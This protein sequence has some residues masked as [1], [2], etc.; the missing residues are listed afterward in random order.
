MRRLRTSTFSSS[1]GNRIAVRAWVLG[2]F[3]RA[4]QPDGVALAQ[5]S[6][7]SCQNDPECHQRF[8]E[9]QRLFGSGEYEKALPLLQSLYYQDRELGALYPIA[10]TL[11]H[12]GKP[13]D[14]IPYFQKLLESGIVSDAKAVEEI[15]KH[16]QSAEDAVRSSQQTAEA[17][18]CRSCD[19]QAP[20]PEPPP[21]PPAIPLLPAPSTERRGPLPL[22]Q[23][24]QLWV[25]VGA[26]ATAVVVIGALAGA[27]AP[28]AWLGARTVRPFQ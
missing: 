25:G 22:Y 2:L 11:V 3:L 1:V 28:P 4:L 17:S 7:G 5:L 20:P 8:L 12:L 27:Y 18:R 9:A 13:E 19:S 10:L 16:K 15:R 14:A 21:T 23:R 26:A 24:W 6:V